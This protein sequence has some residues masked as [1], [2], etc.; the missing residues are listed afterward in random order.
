MKKLLIAFLLVSGA[1]F[2][3]S[4]HEEANISVDLKM[5]SGRVISKKFRIDS[6]FWSPRFREIIVSYIPMTIEMLESNSDKWYSIQNFLE[7]AKKNKG[8]SYLP[9]ARQLGE[10]SIMLMVHPT[11]MP[12]SIHYVIDQ[13]KL[14]MERAVR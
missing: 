3:Q 4:A 11:L 6:E 14:A 10:T 8:D 13:V 5:T 1:S 2:G 7:A 9:V 12:E